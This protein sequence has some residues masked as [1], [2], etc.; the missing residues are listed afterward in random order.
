MKSTKLKSRAHCAYNLN[1]HIVFVTKYRRNVINIE[2]LQT[3]QSIFTRLCLA[4]ECELL[5][6]S[7]E[8]D[9]V[10]LLI[11]YPPNVT[12][13]K[14]INNLKAVSSKLI[15]QQFSEQVNKHYSKPVFWT[16][17]YC[18]ISAGGAPLDVLKTYINSQEKPTS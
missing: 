17:A 11:S 12:L 13:S 18:I 10:H 2:M 14:L 1:A 7:G 9:H 8:T 15:R 4:K 5:E 3:L 6:F 16:Q